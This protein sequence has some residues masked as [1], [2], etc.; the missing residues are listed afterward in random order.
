M[1]YKILYK[2]KLN[3]DRIEHCKTKIASLLDTRFDNF[4][5]YLS[6]K[7]FRLKRLAKSSRESQNVPIDVDK[8]ELKITAQK[9]L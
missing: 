5:V 9:P 2:Q 7:A 1:I 8:Y 3:R 4:G 6:N